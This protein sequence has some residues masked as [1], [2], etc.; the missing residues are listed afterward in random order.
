MLLPDVM[1]FDVLCGYARDDRGYGS[2]ALMYD[3]SVLGTARGMFQRAAKKH[4]LDVVGI[5]E[6]SLFS[7]DYGAQLQRLK[8]KAPECLI[9]WGLSDNTAGIVKE[10]DGLGAAYVDTPTAKSR[11]KWAPQLLGYPGGTGEKTWAELAGNSAKAGSLTAWYLG[12][13]VGGPRFPIRDWLVDYDGHGATGGEEGA[14][15][16]WWALLEAVRRTGSRDRRAIVNELERIP[17]I[18]FAGLPFSFTSKRHLSM[19][20]D[21]VTLIT[22][23]RYSGPVETDPPYVLGR[24]WK[25]TFPLVKPDYVGPVHLVRPRLAANLRAQPDYMKE[26]LRDG[27]GIQCAKVPPDAV[28]TAT[29]MSDAC[30]IH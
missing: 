13:L 30:K 24:E 20:L 21:D 5:E 6:F 18:D 8:Q 25:E 4:D 27:W 7:A 29:N 11:S 26:I 14:P 22:L 9:V 19:T 17:S 1:S 28:G 3:S 16:A 12:G 23:E 15:N 2:V 10:L